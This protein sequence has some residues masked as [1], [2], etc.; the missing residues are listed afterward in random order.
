M[1]SLQDDRKALAAKERTALLVILGVGA[2]FPET[3]IT[4][5]LLKELSE[6]GGE[7]P[8]SF[9]GSR[10]SC[11]PLNYLR[12]TG[13]E[14]LKPLSQIASRFGA[15][16]SPTELGAEACRKALACAKIGGNEIG[17][18]L[19]DCATPEESCPSEAQRIAGKLGLDV[20]A[21]DVCAGSCALA[22]HLSMIDG[23]KPERR[24]KAILCVSTNTPTR[25]VDFRRGRARTIFGD[26]ASAVI[27]G[28]AP[29]GLAMR[30]AEYRGAA[31]GYDRFAIDVYGHLGD[32]A[33]ECSGELRKLAAE[34]AAAALSKAGV[35][36][37]ARVILPPR[38]AAGD[39]GVEAQSVLSIFDRTGDCL[40][41]FAGSVLA[42]AWSTFKRGA[43]VAVAQVGSGTGS[44]ALLL[45][46]V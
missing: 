12:E 4:G 19:A 25:Y 1:Y 44:G 43:E 18:L 35:R 9:A 34:M 21:Y 16:M 28:S 3:E 33:P 29:H 37:K 13:N 36:R 11:L 2:A 42:D 26:A 32:C 23:W 27:A 17:L 46:A 22:L 5:E 40:G 14:S 30:F 20:P 15:L 8:A 45:E 10:R 7:A 24:P 38:T 41:A 31:S 39:C 6:K